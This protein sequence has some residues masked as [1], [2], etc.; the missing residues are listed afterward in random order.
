MVAPG[1]DA[2]G[3]LGVEVRLGLVAAVDGGGA[4][5]GDEDAGGRLGS[6]ADGGLE[7]GDV[8][9]D[10]GGL[11]HDGDGLAGAVVAGAVGGLDVVDDGDVAGREEVI[12]G[13][14]GGEVR[15]EARAVAVADVRTRAEVREIADVGDDAGKRPRE[16]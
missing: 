12:A 11:A 4:G 10:D 3:V 5:V 2:G 7:V 14:G 16:A 9:V 15:L 13:L 6:L 1:A 8:R